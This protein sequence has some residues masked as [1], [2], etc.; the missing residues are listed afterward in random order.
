MGLA[1]LSIPNRWIAVSE[2]AYLSGA[3]VR[4]MQSALA[5][6]PNLDIRYSHDNGCR[7]MFL[8]ADDEEQRRI[9]AHL[10]S[11]RYKNPKVMEDVV[12]H[13]PS[14]GWIT[15]KDLS[16]QTGVHQVDIRRMLEGYPDVEIRIDSESGKLYM[17]HRVDKENHV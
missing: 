1:I 13:I 14:E 8:T 11:W 16:V 3:T 12:S 5:Y 17:Y 15:C 7:R 6:I 10:M 2:I 4:Q 9:F